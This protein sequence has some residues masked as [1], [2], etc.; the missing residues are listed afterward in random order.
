MTA[1]IMLVVERQF[2]VPR[3]ELFR[4][5]TEPGQ[6]AQWRGSPGWHVEAATVTSELRL[7]GKHHHVK[8]LDQDPAVRVTTDAVFTEFHD[9]DVFVARQRITGDAG[10]DP[11]VPLE[12]RVEFLKTGRD[13]TLV[14]IIQG[15]YDDSV[16]YEHSQGWERELTRLQSYLDQSRMGARQ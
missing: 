6:M 7:G 11:A 13:G 9:P 10:I 12:L 8:I 5:W 2:D 1:N 15:P 14:R 4:A 16:A 3:P